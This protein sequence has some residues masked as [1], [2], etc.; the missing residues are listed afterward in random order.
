MGG[1][2]KVV[3]FY[4]KCTDTTPTIPFHEKST[5]T[6]VQ[7]LGFFLV[8]RAGIPSVSSLHELVLS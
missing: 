4:C 6:T 8:S 1:G 2:V 7:A 3:P 5:D